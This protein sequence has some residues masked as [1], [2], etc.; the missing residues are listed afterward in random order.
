MTTDPLLPDRLVSARAGARQLEELLATQEPWWFLDVNTPADLHLSGATAE[1]LHLTTAHQRMELVHLRT[2]GDCLILD[3]R[4]QLA[5]QDEF[6]YHEMLTHPAL[7]LGHPVRRVLI[8]GGGDGCAL[9]E[10]LRWSCVEQARLVDIDEDVVRICRE[11]HPE[12]SAGALDDPRAELICADA[13]ACVEEDPSEVWDLII[14]DLTEPYDPS[15]LAGEL[16]D[17]LFTSSFLELLGSR[18]APGGLLVAQTGGIQC[19]P[20]LDRHHVRLVE[21]LRRAFPHTTIACD[22][23]PSFHELWTVTLAACDP[24][25]QLTPGEVNRRL[26]EG[27]VEALRYY[28]GETHTRLMATPLHLRTLHQ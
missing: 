18:L 28:D 2:R 27:E 5:S 12:W 17:H 11:R 6:I 8:L 19:V 4:I 9:R 22:L 21:L 20:E 1:P 15:G 26:Q 24:L 16:S 7:V 13:R 3:G 25:P 10:V 23:V 14:A